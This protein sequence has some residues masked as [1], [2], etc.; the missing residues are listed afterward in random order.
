MVG[1]RGG[2]MG[3]VGAALEGNAAGATANEAHEFANAESHD[4]LGVRKVR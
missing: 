3:S 4:A 2:E 1:E